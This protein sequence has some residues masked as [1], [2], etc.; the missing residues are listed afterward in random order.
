MSKF[1]TASRRHVQNILLAPT[2]I[3]TQARGQAPTQPLGVPRS[4]E[5]NCCFLSF[6][7][8]ARRRCCAVLAS[9]YFCEDMLCRYSQHSALRLALRLALN[10]SIH[11]FGFLFIHLQFF[12]RPQQRKHICFCVWCRTLWKLR[13]KQSNKQENKNS[14]P[15]EN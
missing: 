11:E 9:A 6:L 12:P 14:K 3:K 1:H 13:H 7:S 2:L 15:N 4:V 5:I 10:C 8:A